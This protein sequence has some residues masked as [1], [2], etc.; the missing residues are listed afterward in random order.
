MERRYGQAVT[1][2]VVRLVIVCAVLGILLLL[3]ATPL[4]WALEQAGDAMAQ[5]LD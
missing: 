4:L 5:A 3:A 2:R 1:D